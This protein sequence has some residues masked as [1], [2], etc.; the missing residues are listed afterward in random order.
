MKGDLLVFGTDEMVDD[1]RDRR[2]APAVAE[3]L[4]AVWAVALDDAGRVV[5]LA[6][7]ATQ[8]SKAEQDDGV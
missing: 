5:G 7:T 4:A 2:H 1:V 6:V 8:S 3:P